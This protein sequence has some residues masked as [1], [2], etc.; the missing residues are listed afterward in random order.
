MIKDTTSPKPE[1]RSPSSEFKGAGVNYHKPCARSYGGNGSWDA[2]PPLFIKTP[3][4]F[5][6]DLK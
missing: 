5:G 4:S 1:L 2:K 6:G 3:A